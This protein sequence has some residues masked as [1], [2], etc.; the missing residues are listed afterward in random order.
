MNIQ[1]KVAIDKQKHPERYCP[2]PRCL[3][4]TAKLN[5]KTQVH[6]GGGYCPHHRAMRPV[7]DAPNAEVDPNRSP[8]FTTAIVS[9]L[10]AYRADHCAS[11]AWPGWTL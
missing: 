4:K 7:S 8:K 9:R 1:A 11:Y 3:W 10:R 6:E 2:A 5:H